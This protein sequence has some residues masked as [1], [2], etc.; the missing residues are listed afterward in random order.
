MPPRCRELAGVPL[1]EDLL[2]SLCEHLREAREHPWAREHLLR[3]LGQR[4]LGAAEDGLGAVG[5]GGVRD[6]CNGVLEWPSRVGG[7]A[8]RLGGS[9]A[10]HLAGLEAE[11]W[12]RH[13]SG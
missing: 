4:T 2:G 5:N 7:R 3:R 12:R 8:L 6:G 11:R 9:H 1:G 10:S 13:A